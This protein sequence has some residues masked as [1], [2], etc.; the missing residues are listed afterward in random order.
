MALD[1]LPEVVLPRALDHDRTSPTEEGGDAIRDVRGSQGE[2]A[3]QEYGEADVAA[4]HVH[5]Q[6]VDGGVLVRHRRHDEPA[7]VHPHQDDPVHGHPVRGELDQHQPFLPAEVAV[8]NVAVRLES[9]LA[10]GDAV[11]QHDGE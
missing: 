8:E 9:D 7:D 3:D 4:K 11:C 1:R 10:F 2:G 6:E 5:P